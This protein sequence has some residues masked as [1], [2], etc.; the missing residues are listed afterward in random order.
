MPQSDKAAA[1]DLE[2]RT[3]PPERAWPGCGTRHFPTFN[4]LSLIPH[5]ALLAL[6]LLLT[7]CR[8]VDYYAQAI[9][10]QCQMW[11]RQ[12]PI[13]TLLEDPATP[14]PLK[15]RLR[16]VLEIR[17]FA[18][19]EL[20]LPANGHYLRYAD[21]GRP[22]VVW[23]VYA[24]P[25]FS[26]DS[27]SWWY[28]VVGK[29]D[30]RGYFNEQK[31][32]GY[33]AALEDQ[34]FDVYVGGV[35]AYSTLGWFRDPVLNTFIHDNDADLAELLFHELAHQRLFVA[36][37][38]DFNEAFATA[39]ADEGSRRWM[40]ARRDPAAQEK[41]DAGIRRRDQFVRLVIQAREKLKSAYGRAGKPAPD[42]RD[43]IDADMRRAKDLVI[44]ELRQGYAKLRAEWG[45]HKDYDHWF[46]Q[47]LNNA[48]LNTVDTYHHLVPAFRHLLREQGGNLESFYRAAA[49]LGKMKKEDRHAR[50]T[51]LLDK[52]P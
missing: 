10:G 17:A 9:H 1:G 6:I 13:Q 12:R 52:E 36:G 48:Q 18:E 19:K 51:R 34:G 4:C 43:Q 16:L 33:A 26:L 21:L 40:D 5:G 27:K 49:A 39:V 38:T 45:G 29:L 11:H 14:E 3:V 47:G 20:R 24:A 41:H 44:D 35:T 31:A 42:R 50:L 46:Q 8:T 2:M 22:Y 23:N 25:E 28:P 15:Q 32:R 37:D 7:G 30:Y